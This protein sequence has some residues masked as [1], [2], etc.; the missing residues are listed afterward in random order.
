MSSPIDPSRRSLPGELRASLPASPGPV[1]PTNDVLEVK[2]NGIFVPSN[3]PL[4][5][6]TV[7]SLKLKLSDAG[8][9]LTT[10]ARVVYTITP[11]H[12]A[13]TNREPGMRMEFLDVWGERLAQQLASF[14]R[15]AA[16]ST[17]PP[18]NR[19]NAALVLVVDDDARYR[20]LS[21]SVMR[22][23]GFEVL[24]AQNGL[25]ALSMAL[26]HRPSL[27]ITDVTMPSMDGWQ[28]LRMVRA[29]PELRRTPVIFLTQLTSDEER[30]RGYQ[31]GVDDYV[32]KPF[33]GVELIARVERALER[34][35]AAEEAVAN[36]MRGDLSK[37]P[38]ASLLTL[39]EMERRSGMVQLT[40]PGE[41]ATLHLRDG[42]VAR[43]DLVEP[44][45]KLE[46][47]ARFFHVLDW[48]AGRFELSTAALPVDDVMHV[49][50][51]FAL[52][53]HARMQDEIA[54]SR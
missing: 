40:R 32:A 6:G 5:V 4:P 18:S 33:T 19:P 41:T 21:A 10:M 3:Q 29:R 34:A 43:I 35:N 31:L 1:L 37:V 38:L 39:A 16:K 54:A 15:E 25:E 42:A 17:S 9:G 30:L 23:S 26:R 8:P 53:E 20:E 13:L 7:I 12:A 51:S 49:R 27:V 52:L 45:A 2:L 24:T 11:E 46:G 48:S 22:E 44:F 50:T 36:G 28:F 47:I 14:L